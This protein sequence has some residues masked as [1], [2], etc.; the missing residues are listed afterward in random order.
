MSE[1]A[2]RIA[3]VGYDYAARE[4]EVVESCNLCGSTDVTELS[5]RDRYGYPASLWMCRRCGLGFLSPRLTPGEYG[6]FYEDVYRPLVSA[7]HGRRIDAETVQEDQHGY[8]AELVEHLRVNLAVPPRSV[9]DVG[10]STGIVAAAV[11]DAFGA[12]ATVLDPAPAELE[13]AAAAGME[14]IAG[15]AEDFDP[16]E[17]RWDLVLLCQTV[18]HLLDVRRTLDSMR[19]MTADD[20]HAFV[21][22]LDLLIA[23]RKH[24]S[25]EGAAKIDHPYY[26]TH[27]TAIAFFRRAGFEP[28]AERLSA[29]GHWGFV[30]APGEPGEPDWDALGAHAAAMIEELQVA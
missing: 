6:V 24:G 3:A 27:G 17:R 22:V 8:A 7:F 4:T 15:F 11:R 29:D 25:V 5:R 14:T 2:D 26:L 21:D 16:A 12:E 10:G 18:D 13:V 28:V 19:R 23:A 20:G 30:L 1:R 9:M